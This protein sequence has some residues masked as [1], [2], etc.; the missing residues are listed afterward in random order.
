MHLGVALAQVKDE[1]ADVTRLKAVPNCE[2]KWDHAKKRLLNKETYLKDAFFVS[3][4]L[5]KV[6]EKM[7]W[8]K[9]AIAATKKHDP[10]VRSTLEII[11]T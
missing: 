10:S 4:S 9:K 2:Q 5:D 6:G 7:T 8:F 3:R 11:I 1:A